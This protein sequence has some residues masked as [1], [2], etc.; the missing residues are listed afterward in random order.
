MRTTCSLQNIYM[1]SE[2]F[3]ITGIKIWRFLLI[4]VNDLSVILNRSFF[5]YLPTVI[6][7]FFITALA[8]GT[9]KC[10]KNGKK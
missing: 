5:S 8:I 4:N 2:P 3:T 10:F 6:C 7:L 1:K 9:D